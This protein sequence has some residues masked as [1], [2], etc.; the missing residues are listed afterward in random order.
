MANIKSKIIK[1]ILIVLLAQFIFAIQNVS[2]AEG[3]QGF[4][5]KIL[6]SGSNFFEDGKSASE[7]GQIAGDDGGVTTI[8]SPDSAKVTGIIEDIYNILFPLGIAVTVIVGGVLGIKFMLA[9]V[10]DKAK[11]KE[12]L[13]PYV[14]GCVVI[15]GAFGI[16]K[17]AIILFSGLG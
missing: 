12:S 8:Q 16:W 11:I 15:Y 10:E 14:V 9:S 2:H 5:D 13:V 7:S 1:V 6:E 3:E 17:L 4:W